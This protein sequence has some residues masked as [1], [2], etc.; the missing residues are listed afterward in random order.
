MKLNRDPVMLTALASAIITALSAFVLPL[1][2]EQQ[3]VLNAVVVAVLGAVAAWAVKGEKLVAAIT[4]LGQA[5][6]AAALAFGADLT[7][8]QQAAA[9][10]L[11][12]LVA[13]MW[14]RTQVVAAVPPTFARAVAVDNPAG[15]ELS[16]QASIP[17]PLV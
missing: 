9:V 3:G 7:P 4:A 8:E 11:V 5:L 17:E 6:I 10:P 13:G 16:S 15:S 1:T 2:Q 14:L 12:A